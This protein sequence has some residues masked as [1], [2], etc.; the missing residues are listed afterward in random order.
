MAEGKPGKNSVRRT[1]V[2]VDFAGVAG[3][4]VKVGLQCVNL[5]DEDVTVRFHFGEFLAQRASAVP[6]ARRR[7]RRQGGRR[8]RHL[9]AVAAQRAVAVV[10]APAVVEF[11]FVRLEKVEPA[12]LLQRRLGAQVPRAVVQAHVEA[13]LVELVRLKPENR[14]KNSHLEARVEHYFLPHTQRDRGEL[15][16]VARED[17]TM[18]YLPNMDMMGAFVRR[19][20]VTEAF[21]VS[22]QHN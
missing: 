19:T 18:Q 16:H 6:Q 21:D 2:A 15:N 12:L 14:A 7:R 17:L 8:Q 20:N 5:A 1:C 9:A 4:G 3:A 10:V 13:A 11:A 22:Y